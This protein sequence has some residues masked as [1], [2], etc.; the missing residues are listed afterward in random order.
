VE[1]S[2]LLTAC[3]ERFRARHPERLLELSMPGPV[4]LE[5][6]PALLSRAVDNLLD[7]AR[8][9]SEGV[10][11]LAARAN[12][13]VEVSVTDH[14][15]GMSEADLSR[16]FTPFFRADPSRT[17]DTG[18]VGLGLSLTRRIAEAHGGR[19]TLESVKGQGTTARLLL[20]R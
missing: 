8:K 2:A 6:D 3:A 9:Y 13:A 14:G 16:A 15:E 18:G 20:P 12:E 5:G 17:R 1:V 7:N 10:V 4:T 19:V 11:T